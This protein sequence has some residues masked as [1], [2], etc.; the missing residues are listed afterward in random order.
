M[1]CSVEYNMK[2]VNLPEYM[3]IEGRDGSQFTGSL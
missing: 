3:A 2:I 1:A